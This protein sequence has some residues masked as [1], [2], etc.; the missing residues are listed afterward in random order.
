MLLGGSL[1]GAR[2]GE[3][4][5]SRNPATGDHLADIPRAGSADVEE[6]VVEARE[7]YRTWANDFSPQERASRLRA[8]ADLLREHEERLGT[9]DAADAG[10]PIRFMI[11]DV[12]KAASYVETIANFALGTGGK[13]LPVSTDSF[14]YTLRQPYGV[15]GRIVP[16]NHPILFAGSKIAAP[17]VAGNSVIL[18]PSEQAPLSALETGKLIAEQN[19]FPDGVV[20]VLPGFGE[21]VGEPLVRHEAVRKI[22]FTG[23]CQTGKRVHQQAGAKLAD[24]SL[25]LGGKNPLLA[26]PDAD[27]ETVIDGTVEGMNLTW[28][29]ESCGSISRLFLHDDHYDTGVDLL[30]RRLAEVNMG[31]PLDDGTGMGCLTDERQYEHVRGYVELAEESDLRTIYRGDPPDAEAI[32]DGY[33]VP[34]IAYGD[35]SMDM[36]VAREEIFGPII[37]VFRWEDEEKLI[38]RAN[39]V[40]Y[41]L[42]A[43][44]YTTDLRTA[45]ETAGR[46]EAGY[47]WINDT[48]T[49]YLGMPFGGWKESGLDYEEGVEE[50]RSYTRKKSVNVA[51]VSNGS[52]R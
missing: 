16:F 38:A 8:F 36:R 22:G 49:H 5:E 40:T 32:S 47:I 44:I 2:S 14:N 39:D 17:L 3:T 42:T 19:V 15:V 23:G 1:T 27:I 37:L 12:E 33:F 41:G 9:L 10:N 29:G 50:V 4:F 21:E 46:L 6:A 18:K 30:Q 26:Y 45:H 11:D 24:I 52:P 48:A 43:S 20:N 25:E 35:V 7:G 31:D 13:T 51:G 34:P 28:Q